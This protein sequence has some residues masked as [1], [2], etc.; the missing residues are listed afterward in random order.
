[1]DVR[2]PIAVVGVSALFP[3]SP[4]APS[5]WRNIAEGADLL[6]E[7]PE[8]HWRIEDYFHSDPD[9][10][11]R[12][13]AR[14][15]GFL[16]YV[17][18]VPS[19][20]GVPPKTVPAIDT[21]QLLALAVA[22]QVLEDVADGDFSHM[23]RDR[24]SVVLGVAS[25]T[26]LVAHM[27]GRLQ[28]PVWE[29]ALR[30][31]GITGEQL[32]QF[33]QRIADAYTPWQADTFPGLLGNVVAGRIANRFDLGGTNCVVDAACASS[34]A[35]LQIALNELYLG[36]SEMVI[37][38]GVDAL[39]D[40]L[41]FMCFAKVTALSPSG[42]CRPFA[43]NADGTMLGE[44]LAM[45]ALK[46]LED[47]ERDGDPI[48]AVIRGLGS[49]SDGRAKSI[50]APRPSGQAQALRRAY[51]AAGY[52]PDTVGL[53]EAHGTAT[54]AGDIAE[55]TALR[56]V[57]DDSGREDRQWC[58]IGS[59]KSQVGHT[60][61][62]A[63]ACGLFKAVMALHHKTLPPTIKVDQ[64]NPALD[65]GTSPFY[66]STQSKPWI[67]DDGVPRR[68]SVS[69]FGFGGTNFHVALEEYTGS[70]RRP[71]RHR[72]WKSEL[73]VLEAGDAAALA[74]KAAR[75]SASLKDDKDML[76][77]IARATQESYDAG[78][79]HRLALVA[80]D[81]ASLRS[82]LDEAAGRLGRSSAAFA[83]PR[84]YYYSA[85][86]P[87]PVALLFPGQGSQYLG[88][89][90]DVPRLFDGALGPWENARTSLVDADSDLHQIV[91]PKTA[92]TEAERRR[93]AETLTSTQWA[94]P[95]IGAHS[96]SLLRIVRALEI[97][98]IAV[99]GHSFGE[100]VALCAAGVFDE[101]AALRV[102]HKR[103]VLMAEAARIGEGTMCAVSAPHEIVCGLLQ[104]W[105][106]PVVIANHNSPT[107]VIVSG[108]KDAV[109]K[110]MNLLS[111]VGIQSKQ[112]N[113]ATA[114]HS[115]LVAGAVAPF[116]DFLD[117]IPF[118][119]PAFP[120]YANA[121]AAPYGSD[122]DTMR[123]TLGEQIAQPVR[124]L[125]MVRSMWAAGARTFVEVGPDGVLT[126]LVGTCLEGL[127]HRAV[128]LD[129]KNAHGI[130]TLWLG[131]AQ[132]VAAGVPM[133]F[134][135]LWADY[136][137]LEDPRTRPEPKLVLKIN[138]AN[139]G[140]PRL[141]DTPAMPYTP[142]SAPAPANVA[143]QPAPLVPQQ[144]EHRPV[145][146]ATPAA[147]SVAVAVG[148]DLV[149]DMLQVVADK[150]GYPVEML[151][152]SM[153][154]E[155]DLGIDSIKRVEILSAVQQRVPSLPE[156]ETSAMAELKTLQEIVD[157]LNTLLPAKAPSSNGA[158]NGGVNGNGN[159]NGQRSGP[160]LSPVSSG[161]V[162]SAPVTATAV[163]TDL[164]ADMLQVVAD[165]TGY[166][167]EMLELSMALEADL[168]IDSIKRVEILSA[169]QQRVPSLPEVET[170]AMAELKTLQEIVDYLNT[171]LPTRAPTLDGAVN[172]ANGN[173]QH[174]AALLS[175]GDRLPFDLAGVPVARHSVRA[176]AAPAQ[177]M[178]IPGLQEA[179]RLEIVG[180]PEAVSAALQTLL[181]S[182]GINAV[183]ADVASAD[184]T[185]V[186]QLGGLASTE[187][188]DRALDVNRRVIAD[189]LRVAPR[190]E[191][192]GGAFI[193]VQDTGG[194]FG[195]LTDAGPRAWAAGAAALTKV[196]AL[197]WP[198]SHTKAIDVDT[199]NRSPQQIAE[200]IA[201][202]ILF[203]GAELE[204]GL[205]ST[206]GRV[207]VATYE[208]QI[209][210]RVTRL[211]HRDVVLVSGG[212]RG[213]T[214]ASVIAMARA[215]QATFVLIGRSALDDEPPTARGLTAPADLKRAL[216][217][218]AQLRGEK[219]TPRELEQ[220]V[221][222]VL[223]IREIRATMSAVEQAGARVAYHVTDVRD[224][225]QLGALLDRVRTEAGPI[226][227]LV[228]GAGV[229][230]DAYLSRKTV[231]QFDRVF[232]TKVGGLRALLDATADDPLKLILLFSS[233][234]ARGG[235]VGQADYAMAN[236]VVNQVALA[237]RT[238]RPGCLVRALGWGPWE[239]GMVT[240]ALKK[241]FESRGIK[242]LRLDDGAAAFVA[243]AFD[244]DVRDASVLLGD[245]V[246][247][248]G[249]P[250]PL[251]ETGRSVRVV[252]DAASYP[253]LDGHRVQQQVV[254]PV[255]QVAEWFVGTAEACRPGQ[256][257]ERLGELQV[258]RG[259]PL[260][261][262]DGGGDVFTVQCLPG[263]DEPHRL[264][265]LLLDAAGTA[266]Y[267]ATA[268]MSSSPRDLPPVV[269]NQWDAERSM[270]QPRYGEGALFHSGA[271]HV[272][273]GFAPCGP[274]G[275]VAR[276]HGLTKANWPQR[277]WATD[278]AAL[279]GCLQV[280]FLWSLE[281]TGRR[282]LPMR[283]NELMLYRGGPADGE[284]WCYLDNGK[285]TSNGST[286][287]LRLTD[288]EGSLIAEL[289]GVE[290]YPYG[291][292]PHPPSPQ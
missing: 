40:I 59:V 118:G 255:V 36:D 44:G 79:K 85:E 240:P 152:L 154:L 128:A 122:A 179:D 266:R 72:S 26:E 52:G 76:C 54:K 249:L 9:A 168:G 218:E 112:L 224:T 34:L 270:Q 97:D 125:E 173:G 174:S 241:L 206:H 153:A 57:F 69:S 50:Y 228:H 48:Y 275:A 284:L 193:T 88:M 147:A 201:D 229:V 225:V 114:F 253:Y 62:A 120:V 169:V 103:G 133:N 25:A 109:L 278:P 246:A 132:L 7:V 164:V 87:G 35:A 91:W 96:L 131:L 86:E 20:F 178:G 209:S 149:A 100:V 23:D 127:P 148:A 66:L 43:D 237:E 115:H 123:V 257:V 90:A 199:A 196:A 89:G 45:L 6:S 10:P 73:V 14:R 162:V 67:A 175:G 248:D 230:A 5:F 151:E 24:V 32:E 95:A 81:V 251:P 143:I 243:E 245:G 160:P 286:Y 94:Q 3:D 282:M 236:E 185:H 30:G 222:H 63:G 38:G 239:A 172:G 18:F 186:L 64:P 276:L 58:A 211:G 78:A 98:P 238:R 277:Y 285:A 110:A 204:V 158:V 107:Q 192:S 84:G 269:A 8:S 262:F 49:S 181:R 231:D 210:G 113:V 200:L 101:E 272:L 273:E 46:R 252:V 146:A 288:A 17:D 111:E 189:A 65:I 254:L 4:D 214:A 267:A 68:A 138:G 220:Q 124:F 263:Q 142:V 134:E 22:K 16:P 13:Y 287:D 161:S 70:G 106:L 223:A 129:R 144:I 39:N 80:D 165:K 264:R 119:T 265:L 166:P 21:A 55:F 82:M 233:A 256:H 29:R 157:Y 130:R 47:A 180:G 99:G 60:K 33:K 216:L 221:Q 176:I 279:D 171:L 207:T 27:S 217:T 205:G 227:G 150:T 28:A 156:V 194:T 190:M 191:Q 274:S 232:G 11:D 261:G 56:E 235:N 92:F 197:E 61:A 93:Q 116:A 12:M 141:D 1:M 198:N 117:E 102:A 75:L 226:T 51:D 15:G 167:V 155:A 145:P 289:R 137:V 140:K 292:K 219:P 212:A 2:P 139:Y 188:P 260:H 213:V 187:G 41:M 159:G 71:W 19:D 250:H 259:V 271:F 234:A 203:G 283:I 215:T 136:R 268:E 42:D 258:I 126:N 242:P 281:Q 291:G 135:S 105:E 244:S 77:Y 53:I 184:A 183:V 37:T 74:D 195:L 247:H 208:S 163:G 290:M 202:E 280:G 170:S 31:S 121:T 182:H 83:S 177:G 104:R 108:A